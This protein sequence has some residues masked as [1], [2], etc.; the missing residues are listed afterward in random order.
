MSKNRL[1]TTVLVAC[2]FGFLYIG[3]HLTSLV[4]PNFGFCLIKKTTGIPCPSCGATRAVL[5][6]LQGDLAASLQMNPL[7]MVIAISMLLIPFWMVF[8]LLS[9]K[10]SFF[11]WYTKIERLLKQKRIALPLLFLV[12]LNWIWTLYKGL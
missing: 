8:D 3:Y 7:G 4:T 5:L 9:K 2:F 1:Y 11:T 12:I 6:L 10:E